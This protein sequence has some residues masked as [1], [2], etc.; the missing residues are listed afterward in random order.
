MKGFAL[1]ISL[2]E[3]KQA[4]EVVTKTGLKWKVITNDSQ[5]MSIFEEFLCGFLKA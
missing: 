3:F 4:E 2:T 1:T 5:C